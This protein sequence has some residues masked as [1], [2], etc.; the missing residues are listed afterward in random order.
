MKFKRT[1]LKRGSIRRLLSAVLAV[2]LAIGLLPASTLAATGTGSTASV[3]YNRESP[4]AAILNRYT[5]T[6]ATLYAQLKGEDTQYPQYNAIGLFEK[7]GSSLTYGTQVKDNATYT[8]SDYSTSVLRNLAIAS[9][10]LEVNLSTTF[11]NRKHTHSHWHNITLCKYDI[12]SYEKAALCL[13]GDY[14]VIISGY[15]EKDMTYPRVGDY[16]KAGVNASAPDSS[17]SYGKVYYSDT[18]TDATLEF[19]A[20]PHYYYHYDDL[21]VCTCGGTY[22]ENLLLTYRDTRAPQ[23]TGINYSLDGGTTWTSLWA[24]AGV[25][26]EHGT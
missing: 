12:T 16:G 2:T 11:Y 6:S 5:G 1:L 15:A 22:A 19:V 8:W 26:R 24:S 3:A 10:N 4:E 13:G 9:G 18:Y 20:D 21:K 7:D 14:P 17:D 25:R 23:V